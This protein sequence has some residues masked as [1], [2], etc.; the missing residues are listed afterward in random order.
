MA[1]VKFHVFRGDN[2]GSAGCDF[3]GEKFIGAEQGDH[4]RTIP[5]LEVDPASEDL[6][7]Q[8]LTLGPSINA[9]FDAICDK[10]PGQ[11]GQLAG[12]LGL[13]GEGPVGIRVGVWDD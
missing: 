8:V 5:Q 7:S 12:M 11:F 2:N 3:R 9:L 6:I 13:E 10:Q 1:A 4:H